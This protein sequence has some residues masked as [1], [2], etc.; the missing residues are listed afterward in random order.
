MSMW[1]VIAVFVIGSVIALVIVARPRK[2]V[3]NQYDRPTTEE[4]VTLSNKQ[5]PPKTQSQG[6]PKALYLLPIFF[7][8]FGD[9]AG[10][11]IAA[12]KY[13]AKWWQMIVLGLL[14]SALA[15]ILLAVFHPR[16]F[17]EK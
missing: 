14:S 12:Q 2:K 17:L 4:I 9:I 5:T 3:V 6:F 13:K 15:Y 7:G 8:L 16:V 1:I 10:G 11:L